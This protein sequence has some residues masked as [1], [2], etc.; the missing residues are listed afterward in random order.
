MKPDKYLDSINNGIHI[1]V[2]E[3]EPCIIQLKNMEL[4][5]A[6]WNSIVL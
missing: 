2:C 5:F 6:I 1:C 4:L 3:R